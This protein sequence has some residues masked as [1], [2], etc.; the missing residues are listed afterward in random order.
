MGDVAANDPRRIEI[1]NKIE[2]WTA[3]SANKMV[4]HAVHMH[5]EVFAVEDICI[6]SGDM[7]RGADCN[8]KCNNLWHRDTFYNCLER[9]CREEG[10]FFLKVGPD[11][12]SF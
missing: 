10:I 3:V 12:S 2:Y 1:Q 9:R 5:A 6:Y 11:Y 4:D 8:T 7:G